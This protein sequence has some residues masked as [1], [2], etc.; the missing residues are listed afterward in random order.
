MKG[1]KKDRKKNVV[2]KGFGKTELNG[3]AN[4]KINMYI[5]FEYFLVD[6]YMACHFVTTNF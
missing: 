1:K 6:V 4:L 5:Y 3:K 2:Q